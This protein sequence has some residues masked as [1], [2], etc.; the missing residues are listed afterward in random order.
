MYKDVYLH[1]G[2][3]KTG[4]SALQKYVFPNVKG[5]FYVGKYEGE[6]ELFSLRGLEK[7]LYDASTMN[8]EQFKGACVCVDIFDGIEFPLIISEEVVVFNLFRPTLWRS[9]T[10][11]VRDVAKN[12]SFLEKFYGVRLHLLMTIRKQ[13]EMLT[14]IYAQC[15]N[16]C[17]SRMNNTKSF[18]D[19]F[20]YFFDGSDLHKSLD[21]Y[22]AYSVYSEF[23]DRVYLLVYERMKGE[24]ELMGDL[25]D[26][27]GVSLEGVCL[28]PDNVRSRKGYKK[29]D[30][31]SLSDF[32]GALRHKIFFLRHVKLPFLRRFLHRFKLKK[33]DRVSVSI[34]MTEKQKKFVRDFYLGSNSRVDAVLDVDLNEYGYLGCQKDQENVE[35]VSASR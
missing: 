18:D 15:F 35:S 29:V 19:F 32:L 12:V 4:T 9:D 16:S 3:P 30:D 14:S 25:S 33:M 13:E 10:L 26:I 7:L 1:V 5:Y 11:S 6:A 28:K 31:Y 22:E 24:C 17:Y 27:F 8:H 23:F 21:Y 2:Y 20:A 34:A